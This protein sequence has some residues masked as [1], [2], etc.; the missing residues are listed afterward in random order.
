MDASLRRVDELI[1]IGRK[2]RVIAL[3]SAVGGMGL[4]LIGMFLAAFGYLPPVAGV[5][6]QE[7]FDVV[8][9]L[10]ALRVT[11]PVKELADFQAWRAVSNQPSAFCGWHLSTLELNVCLLLTADYY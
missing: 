6:T 8:A 2:M 7:I 9:V 3:Q 4:S 5:I 11:L 1:H 10:N